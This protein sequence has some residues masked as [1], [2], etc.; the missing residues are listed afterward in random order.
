MKKKDLINLNYCNY[1]SIKFDVRDFEKNYIIILE[2]VNWEEV[3][4]CLDS[5]IFNGLEKF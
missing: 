5:Y 4:I 3:E 2:N 1:S